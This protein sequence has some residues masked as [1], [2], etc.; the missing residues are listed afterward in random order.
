MRY[1]RGMNFLTRFVVLFVLLH[2]VACTHTA[3]ESYRLSSGYRVST[4]PVSPKAKIF[5]I[6]G[7]Q[8]SA[9]FSQEIIDQKKFWLAQGYTHEEIACYYVPPLEKGKGDKKQFNE[10][11]SE[12]RDC[13]FA[14]PRILFS[15]ILEVAKTKPESIYVY[16]SSH[17][18][19]PMSQ[20]TYSYKDA[21]ITQK[22][23]KVMKLPQWANAYNM[24]LQG[25]V[26]PDIFWIHPNLY[27]GYLFALENPEKADDYI[28]TPRGLKKALLSLP[29]STKKV[30]VLQGCHT[31]GFI[32]PAKEVSSENT[33]AGMK[34]TKVLTASR[35]DRTSFGCNVGAHTT[36]FGE[37]FMN[38][39]RKFAEKK[40]SQDVDWNSVYKF[41]QKQIYEREMILG[42]SQEALSN[43][44]F[45]FN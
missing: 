42:I 24:E 14:D 31:G 37:I 13:Y 41:T 15:H 23:E 2:F 26:A 6:A 43:P 34:N 12:L 29:E 28:F 45:Y 9:N 21:A 22:M 11:F 40:K 19:R 17:G 20:N 36:I 3:G 8:D 1:K 30:V 4:G 5:L 10:L 44:Q 32:L 18:N 35:S 27:K 39:L 33:L 38:S 7:S 25:Y 16:V